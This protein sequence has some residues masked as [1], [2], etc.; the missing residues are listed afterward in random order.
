LKQQRDSV[1]QYQK[2]IVQ[3]LAKE[4]EIAKQLLKDNKKEF[5]FVFVNLNL[6]LILIIC[7]V[8][9]KAL[10][11]L[12]KKKYMESILDKTDNQ[13]MT[14]EKLAMDIEF[15]QVEKTVL[16]GL[17]TGNQALKQLHDILAIDQIE[18]ILDETKEGIEKQKVCLNL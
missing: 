18:A 2:R 14:L 8:Y 6:I 9:R 1:K 17:Q 7:F 11:L 5:S 16:E 13:L 15:S 12:K 4:R 3:Q 10:S